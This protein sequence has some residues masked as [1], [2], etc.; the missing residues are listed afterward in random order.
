[1]LGQLTTHSAK[2]P[3]DDLCRRPD[4]GGMTGFDMCDLPVPVREVF[5]GRGLCFVSVEAVEELVAFSEDLGRTKS[6]RPSELRLYVDAGEA[7]SGA[8]ER[9]GSRK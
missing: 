9:G 3:L 2:P 6:P 1:M 8:A 7:V 5:C 4:E